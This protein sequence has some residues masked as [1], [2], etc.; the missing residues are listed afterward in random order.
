MKSY[1]VLLLALACM[2]ASLAHAQ[3]PVKGFGDLRTEEDKQKAAK[4]PEE[5]TP[6]AAPMDIAAKVAS[7]SLLQRVSQLMLVTM[8]G[9]PAPNSVD[10]DVLDRYTPGGVIIP[11]ILR[12][13]TAAEYVI[14]LRSKESKLGIP[15]LIGTDLY[16][17]PRGTSNATN[18]NFATTPTLLA[19]AAAGDP[20]VTQ[21]LSKFTADSLKNMGFNLHLG[22][23]LELAPTL[24]GVKGTVN[25]LGSDPAFVAECGTVMLKALNDNGVIGLPMGFPGGGL[26]REPKL[27]AVLLSPKQQAMEQDLLPYRKAIEQGAPIIHVGNTLVPTLDPNNLPASLSPAVMDKL[28][29]GDFHFQGV[30]LAGPLDTNDIAI[31]Y[32]LS[33]ATI[34]ALKAGADMILWTQSGRRVMKTVD[35]VVQAVEKGDLVEEAINVSVTRVLEMKERFKLRTHPFPKPKEADAM[36][37]KSAL[38]REAYELERKSVTVVQNNEKVL[39]LIKEVSTPLG[40]T[41]VAGVSA[42]REALLKPLKAVVEQNIATA[43]YGGQVYDFEMNRLTNRVQGMKTVVV[44]VSPAITLE[45]QLELMKRFQSK[46]IKVVAVLVGY[47]GILPKLADAADAIVLAYCDPAAVDGAMK[48]VADILIGRAPLAIEAAEQELKLK[49]GQPRAFNLMEIV[50]TPAGRL[51]V[52]FDPPFTAGLAVAY[53]PGAAIKKVVWDFGDGGKAKEVAVEHTYA[54]PGRYPVTVTVTDLQGETTTRTVSAV[55]E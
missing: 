46:G 44:V 13:S 29:R 42:L 53:D 50:R 2:T 43:K 41:G 7:M 28:L 37:K 3:R 31:K 5:G 36:S 35:D 54:N 22:P 52:S 45:S 4:P 15:L 32:D 51:P 27:P 17:L 23:T 47:P 8:E 1:G 18:P 10:R 6:E 34:M 48:A 38:P 40:V 14:A 21:R 11:S 24:S 26:N 55:V 49:A 12:P 19:V 16:N 20:D 39:P 33:E 30:V 9:A 25:C